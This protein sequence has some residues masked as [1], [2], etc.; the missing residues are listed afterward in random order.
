LV[1]EH[2]RDYR[3]GPT[4]NAAL[5]RSGYDTKSC[6]KQSNYRELTV[7]EANDS[8]SFDQPSIISKR[9]LPSVRQRGASLFRSYAGR[10]NAST[11]EC[12]GRRMRLQSFAL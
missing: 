9:V 4:V 6:F 10:N 12:S 8:L 11:S 2:A 3:D 1:L 5:R 7:K